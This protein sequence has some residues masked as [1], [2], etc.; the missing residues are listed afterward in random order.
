MVLI[1][2]IIEVNNKIMNNQQEIMI[3]MIEMIEKMID[4]LR[5]IP[6]IQTNQVLMKL[7]NSVEQIP[8]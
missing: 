7:E 5:L 2:L 1:K 8:T 4:H 3:E 6:N